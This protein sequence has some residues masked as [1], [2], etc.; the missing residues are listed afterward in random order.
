MFKKI[1][2]CC[3]GSRHGACAGTVALQ[4]AQEQH[5]DLELISI[6]E[7]LPSYMAPSEVIEEECSYDAECLRNK[8]KGMVEMAAKAGVHLEAK[9]LR[10]KPSE[11][12]LKTARE[13]GADLI[14]LGKHTGHGLWVHQAAHTA[15]TIIDEAPCAVLIAN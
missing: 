9:V 4:L 1:L 14:V 11:V 12:I 13:Y 6:V 5:A 2:V 3:D 7:P 8:Q 15:T 10:G